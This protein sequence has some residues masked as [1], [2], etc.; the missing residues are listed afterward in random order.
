MDV[1]IDLLFAVNLCLNGWA[2]WLVS[3]LVGQRLCLRN[4][5]L[6]ATLGAIYGLGVVTP[7]AG[8]FIHPLSKLVLALLMLQVAFRPQ[9]WVRLFQ[10]FG[11]FLLVSFATAGCILGI[12]SFVPSG[13]LLGGTLAWGQ[14]PP[15]VL[16]VA[17]LGL[18]LGSHRLINLLENRLVHVA[19][20]ASISF[21]L[22]GKVLC[23][24]GLVDSGNQLADPIG[25][26]PV[27]IVSLAAVAD[28]L[29]EAMVSLALSD[30]PFEEKLNDLAD[31]PWAG[32]IR[33]IP[34]HSIGCKAGVLLGFRVD[35][36]TI[37]VQ[38]ATREAQNVVLA[39]CAYPLSVQGEYQAL[40]PLRLL[41][42]VAKSTQEVRL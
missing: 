33:F 34:Y 4:L 23:L 28:A 26:R 35:K 29:P 31:N 5:L 22:N 3:T 11:F 37:S 16:I 14:L 13:A 20:R 41:P 30:H 1:Y 21:E 40:I 18:G 25:G 36:V 6:S 27:A 42:A 12:Y 19:N 17:V 38:S 10:L 39:V 8:F 32:R 15:W 9:L 2:L 24:T 7:W